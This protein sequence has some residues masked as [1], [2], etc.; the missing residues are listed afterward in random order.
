VGPLRLYSVEVLRARPL[1][2]AAQVLHD[3]VAGA[4]NEFREPRALRTSAWKVPVV[5][6]G[7][8]KRRCPGIGVF[9]FVNVLLS[10]ARPLTR[11]CAR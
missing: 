8:F 6:D 4:L 9:W 2:G 10:E 11:T 7:G 1:V 5:A 3:G